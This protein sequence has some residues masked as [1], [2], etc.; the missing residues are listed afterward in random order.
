MTVSKQAPR[1]IKYDTSGAPYVVWGKTKVP[2]SAFWRELARF[3]DW[4]LDYWHAMDCT[5]DLVI[6]LDRDGETYVLGKVSA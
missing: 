4:N 1:T 3:V 6:H 2:V 5:R